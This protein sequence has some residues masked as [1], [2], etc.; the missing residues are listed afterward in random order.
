MKF[1]LLLL[2]AIEIKQFSSKIITIIC[3]ILIPIWNYIMVRHNNIKYLSNM[4]I[5][6][7][8]VK[9]RKWNTLLVII[10]TLNFIKFHKM[11]C[12]MK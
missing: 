8:I 7:I 2:G 3:T 11:K 10:I 4:I 12:I 9:Q 6:K 1:F 5:F